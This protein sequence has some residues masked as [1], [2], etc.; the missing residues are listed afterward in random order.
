MEDSPVASSLPESQ[1]K[2]NQRNRKSSS[3]GGGRAWSTEEVSNLNLAHWT[4]ILIKINS[5]K[6]ISSRPECIKCRT[7]ISPP[8]WRRPSWHAASIITSSRKETNVIDGH[9][10]HLSLQPHNHLHLLREPWSTCSKGN[11]PPLILPQTRIRAVDAQK[12][13]HR[14]RRTMCPFCPNLS[15]APNAPDSR[16]KDYAWLPKI[17]STSKIQKLLIW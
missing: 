1:G 14:R 9:P 15:P 11:F 2:P 10:H 3:T 7:S 8:I 4:S 12:A 13:F 6:P 16:S 5:R 17:L